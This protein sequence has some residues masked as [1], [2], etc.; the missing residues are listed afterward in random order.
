MK[1][2][3]QTGY[4]WKRRD[5]VVPCLLAAL[6]YDRVR[7]GISG[8]IRHPFWVVDYSRSHGGYTRVGRVGAPWLERGP[9]V[10]HLY[11]PGMSYWEN[12]GGGSKFQDGAYLIFHGG[13]VTGLDRLI[14]TRAGYAR[15]EDP[16][17]MVGTMLRDVA[18]GG[19][20][21][22]DR[23]F[24][25]AQGLFLMLVD[26]LLNAK[27]REGPFY[28]L[29]P[30]DAPVMDRLVSAVGRY[31][32]EHAAERVTLDSMAGALNVSPST[33]SHRYAAMTGRSPLAELKAVRINLARSLLLRGL[34]LDAVAEQTGFCDAF[35]LSKVFKRVAGVSPRDFIRSARVAGAVEGRRDGPGGGLEP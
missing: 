11:P 9:L 19:A 28:T 13:E 26:R 20:R 15:I 21:E 16:E 33:L 25:R 3:V 6:D 4:A 7:S 34:R 24:W 12:T 31:C 32:R 22:G 27:H 2:S 8:R 14:D 23:G 17:G 35:H 1:L 10:A 5:G 29:G 18:V 30:A